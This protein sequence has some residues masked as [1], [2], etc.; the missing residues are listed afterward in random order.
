M[1][2]PEL[3]DRGAVEVSMDGTGL[4]IGRGL[5]VV[6]EPAT[7][8]LGGQTASTPDR[9]LEPVRVERGGRSPDR[10]RQEASTVAPAP[11]GVVPPALGAT[12][13]AAHA[14]A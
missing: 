3:L 13:Q 1:P 6:A 2:G 5:V 14:I 11:R 9:L 8:V 7:L 4:A 10:L 12:R